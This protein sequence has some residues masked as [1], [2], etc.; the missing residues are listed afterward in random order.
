MVKSDFFILPT[1]DLEGFGLVT[2]ESMSCGTPVLGTPVGATRE[3]LSKFNREFL[4]DDTT[5]SA[6]ACG[7]QAAVKNY[8]EDEAKYTE[9]RDNCR[10]FARNNY[11]WQRHIQKLQSI[12][13]SA[14]AECHTH[15]N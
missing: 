6:M 13:S 9:L 15:L 12:I 1:R 5:P 4:F 11:A 2:P 8:L 7:I 14:I 3:I 10:H